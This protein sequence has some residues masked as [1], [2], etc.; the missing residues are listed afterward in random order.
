MGVVTLLGVWVGQRGRMTFENVGS[1]VEA[2]QVNKCV[3]GT[4]NNICDGTE[5][6]G[7]VSLG[8]TAF[9]LWPEAEVQEKGKEWKDTVEKVS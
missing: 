7:I 3:P 8:K 5:A 6:R 4:G 9:S 2:R 1:R